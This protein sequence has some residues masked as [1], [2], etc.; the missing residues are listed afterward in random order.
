[1]QN[2]E[3]EESRSDYESVAGDDMVLCYSNGRKIRKRPRPVVRLVRLERE[4]PP[5]LDPFRLAI[6][7]A[8]AQGEEDKKNAA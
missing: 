2:E 8:E 1:M 7:Y 3:R 4:S 6:G 5:H